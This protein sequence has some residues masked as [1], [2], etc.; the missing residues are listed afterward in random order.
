VVET[1]RK[2]CV[3][4]LAPPNPA[5]LRFLREWQA[6]TKNEQRK[7]VNMMRSSDLSSSSDDEVAPLPTMRAAQLA[8]P[9][10]TEPDFLIEELWSRE[11]VGI[12]GGQPKCG[13]S[14]LALDL[15]VAV[16]SGTPCLR[17]FSTRQ[18]GTVLI[19]N[20]E[21]AP[22]IVR[23][24]LQGIAYVAG[25]DF[26]SLDVHL[27]TVP[28]LRLDRSEDQKA[29]QATVA[30]HQPKLL[31]LDPLV[32]LHAVDENVTREVAP[33]SPICDFYS[34][35]IT[36]RWR[37]CIMPAR[38]PPMIAG[39]RLSEDHQNYMP[40]ATPISICVARARTCISVSSIALHPESTASSSP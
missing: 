12:I 1:K 20:G 13:K 8:Q 17:H 29:L 31:V 9:E 11:A 2:C 39:A 21:D 28:T 5:D 4:P 40:G 24:R 27:I 14:F 33:S 25:V 32:R 15:A 19:Y 23:Q 36:L 38:V 26:E 7:L 16:A 22:H 3:R 34:V 6:V 35:N 30:L 10:T 18:S 37:W